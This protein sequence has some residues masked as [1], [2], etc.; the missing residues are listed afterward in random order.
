MTA[1]GMDIT[2][3]LGQSAGI[4]RY[5]RSLSGV[6]ASQY[7]QVD[8]RW[9]ALG[10][11]LPDVWRPPVGRLNR[12]PV[13]ERN[14]QRLWVRLRLPLPVEW[15]TGSIDLFHAPDF[16]LPPTRRSTR[17]VVTVHD[18]AFERFPGDTMPGMLDFLRRV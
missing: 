17:T 6:L 14:M 5:V 11:D 8:W 4:G 15:W 1:I 7:D 12:T 9:L 2:A 13:S 10:Q 3:A 16:Y 18:L